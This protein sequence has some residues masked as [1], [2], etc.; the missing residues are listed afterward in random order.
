MS[1]DK[2]LQEKKETFTEF[3]EVAIQV[4]NYLPNVINKFQ[5]KNDYKLFSSNIAGT[6]KYTRPVNRIL[7]IEDA[8]ELSN[9]IEKLDS[10]FRRI[11]NGDIDINIS[12]K[13]IINSALYTIQQAIGIGL[14]LL[15]N[16]NSARKHVG[17]RFEEL[18]KIIFTEIGI[19]NKKIVLKI[20]YSTEEGE[21][22]YNCENDLVLSPFSEVKSISTKLHKKEIVVS[23]KTTSKDR[24]GKMFID[25]LLLEKF[26]GHPQKVIGIFLN[27]VQRKESDNISFTLVSGLFMVYTKFLTELEGIYYFDPPPTS[28][29]LPYSDYMKPFSELITTD[30][31]KLLTS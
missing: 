24:M 18:I 13:F 26:V 20:P 5:I 9:K 10:I 31:F 16:P 6:I 19:A 30:V 21:K 23:V 14:D 7:F 25:K 22:V 11:K 1:L 12:D 28:L 4:L 15:V 8:L 3:K 29:K 2:V 27:D 17:N